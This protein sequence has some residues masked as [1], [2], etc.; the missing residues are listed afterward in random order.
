MQSKY[1]LIAIAAF[2]VTT[3]GVQAYVGNKELNRAGISA[4]Q[5]EAFTQAREL[6]LQ[7]EMEKARDV[8]LEAGVDESVIKSLKQALYEARQKLQQSVES[9]DYNVFKDSIIGTPLADIITTEEDFVTFKEVHIL[10]Q[11]GDFAKAKELLDD[12]GLSAM[13]VKAYPHKHRSHRFLE[14]TVE[15]HD[16]LRVARQ[17]NDHETT[18]A[19]LAEAGIV[20]IYP[21]APMFKKEWR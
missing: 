3:T 6:R 14:L 17:A 2:A 8:L 7:G 19:I 15:Q 11:E 21:R 12:L 4:Q 9:G 13:S 10:K 16:A 1:L 5:V 18:K 20:D